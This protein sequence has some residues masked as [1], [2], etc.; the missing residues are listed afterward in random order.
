MTREAREPAHA[1]P[2]KNPAWY[3]QHQV[4]TQGFAAPENQAPIPGRSLVGCE[5]GP[6]AGPGFFVPRSQP[7]PS[8]PIEYELSHA[9]SAR[10]EVKQVSHALGNDVIGIVINDRTHCRT[11]IYERILAPSG[12]EFARSAQRLSVR[13]KLIVSSVESTYPPP[14][15]TAHPSAGQGSCCRAS[16]IPLRGHGTRIDNDQTFPISERLESHAGHRPLRIEQGAV[17]LNDCRER[18]AGARNRQEVFACVAF[19]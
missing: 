17:E 16:I 2:A 7:L 14:K 1:S 9:L 10:L 15:T 8:D 6:G 18:S 12:D 5:H 11:G 4:W 19:N 3:I 13:M